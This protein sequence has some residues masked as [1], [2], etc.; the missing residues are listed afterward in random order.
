[1][2]KI[3]LF[4]VL[5]QPGIHRLRILN[6]CLGPFTHSSQRVCQELFS[7]VDLMLMRT[8]YLAVVPAGKELRECPIIFFIASQDELRESRHYRLQCLVKSG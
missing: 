6:L 3:H 8:A 4:F 7:N 5:L 1:M 2:F